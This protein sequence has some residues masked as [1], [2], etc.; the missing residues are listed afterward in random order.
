MF[1]RLLRNYSHIQLKQN[2]KIAELKFNRPEGLIIIS[3]LQLLSIHEV[4]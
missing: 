1:R 3:G 4:F 2:G